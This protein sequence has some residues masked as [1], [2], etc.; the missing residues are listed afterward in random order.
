[1]QLV[2]N[3]IIFPENLEDPCHKLR[4]NLVFVLESNSPT[5]SL[6]FINYYFFLYGN[7]FIL[8]V[9]LAN[10]PLYRDFKCMSTKPT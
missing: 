5:F 6:S 3:K 1:M 8:Y 9:F 4:W 2:L 10:D 7:N